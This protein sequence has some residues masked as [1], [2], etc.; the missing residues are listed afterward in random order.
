MLT[1]MGQ[2]SRLTGGTRSSKMWTGVL[3]ATLLVGAAVSAQAGDVTFNFNS[4]T[5]SGS[6]TG[7][8]Q[9]ATDE[10]AIEANMDA[11]LASQCS[12]CTV[13]VSGAA[14]DTTYNGDGYV[15]GPGTPN[16]FTGTVPQSLTLGDSTGATASN[17][18]STLQS[19][20]T[21]LANTNDSSQQLSNEIT[22]TF[23]GLAGDTFT[24]DS[25]DYEIFPCGTAGCTP[26]DMGFDVNGSPVSSFGTNGVQLAVEPGNGNGNSVSSPN[27]NVATGNQNYYQYIGVWNTGYSFTA[28]SSVELEF[29]D[30]PATIGIDNLQISWTTPSPSPVPEPASFVLLGT[31]VLGVGTAMKRRYGHKVHKG[32]EG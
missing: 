22:L 2:T 25:F 13:T 32:Q 11:A 14:A 19:Y 30:W 9:V 21:F 3:L 7:S 18:N 26:P 28:G 5:P 6:G 17:T 20:D 31:A 27:G 15:T 23:T 24:V 1:N 16:M 29:I 10:A 4:L 8:T 12:S